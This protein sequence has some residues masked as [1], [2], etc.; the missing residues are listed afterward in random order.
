MTESSASSESSGDTHRAAPRRSPRS[1]ALT[2]PVTWG[3]IFVVTSLFGVL[4]WQRRW[5]TDDGL[6]VVRTVRQILAGHGPVYNVLE[7]AE[8][9]TSAL[10]TAMLTA[11]GAL[12]GGDLAP[13]ALLVGGAC[14][15]LGLLIALDGTRRFHHRRGVK[16]PLLVAGALVPVAVFPFWDFATS[17][18]ETGLSTLWLAA[19]WWLLVT[20]ERSSSSRRRAW[21]AV[22]IGLGPLVRPDFGVCMLVFWGASWLLVTP[23]WR[24][25]LRLLAVSLALP[26]AYEVFRAGYYGT[27]VPLPALAKSAASPSG[28]SWQRGYGYV[29]DFV[30]PYH[31]WLP[32]GVMTLLLAHAWFRGRLRRRDGVVILAPV[33]SALLLLLYLVSVGGDFMHGRMCLPPALLL[34]LPG[35]LWPLRRRTA[36]AILAIAAWAIVVGTQVSEHE[37]QDR[38]I[39]DE[40]VGYAEYTGKPNPIHASDFVDASVAAKRVARALR[41]G[42]RLLIEERGGRGVPLSSACPADVVFAVGRLGMG[43]AATPLDAIVADTNGLASPL[44]ARITP[45][46]PG[47]SGHEKKLPRA[48]V[49]A[50]YAD[51]QAS[52]GRPRSRAAVAAAGR[53]M[54]CGELAELLE[55]VRAPMTPR[56]FWANLKGSWRRTWLVIPADPRDAEA[57]FCREAR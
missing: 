32:Y 27:L 53:A 22:V 51:P 6:I 50:D 36:L 4:A 5:I 49:L 56:R 3:G 39:W 45:T 33:V 52:M 31:L 10:W 34:L 14:A 54:R 42:E 15:V 29:L 55:S 26:L 19:I 40:R 35:L 13:M 9:N 23:S 2:A 18:L 30:V 21:T 17:G 16:G 12:S 41:R 24:E 7:R 8:S 25:T 28:A 11:A 38:P 20:L 57:K 47:V 1:G 48:W 46:R 43:G 44:G 37:P